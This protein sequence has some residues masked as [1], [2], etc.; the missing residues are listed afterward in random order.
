MPSKLQTLVELEGFEDELEFGE[1]M[2]MDSVCPGICCNKG[3]D[4]TTSVEPD[5]TRGYCDSCGTQTV[6]SGLILMGVI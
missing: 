6:K 4:Y 2:L 3:C 1:A 5:C